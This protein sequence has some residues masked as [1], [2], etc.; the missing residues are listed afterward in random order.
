ML[1]GDEIIQFKD[2]ILQSAGVYKLSGLLRGRRGTE[3]AMSKHAIGD[4]AVLL[5]TDS[6]Y[7]IGGTV[8]EL[9]LARDYRAVSFDTYL[10]ETET[11]NFTDTGV[12]LE[13][14]SPVQIGGGRNTIGDLSLK[15]IRRS[16]VGGEWR[17]YADVELGE[18]TEAYEVDVMYG[19]AVK[20]TIATTT[21]AAT[22]TA[23]DQIAD[24]GSVQGIVVVY[25]YQLSA[26]VGRGRPG[27]AS[28]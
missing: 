24:F 2:A 28:I 4:R 8:G 3:W 6:I 10:D 22:Y 25:V 15:W 16:R 12:G 27:V 23:A 5:T 1:I 21:P 17:D 13:C 14:Y 18:T 26:T 7:R 11:V 9:N 20:R 19:N